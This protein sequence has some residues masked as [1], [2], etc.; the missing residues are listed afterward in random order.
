MRTVRPV[1]VNR[2]ACAADWVLGKTYVTP[3][4]WREVLLT[5]LGSTVTESVLVLGLVQ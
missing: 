5:L 4:G 1:L 3:V 2:P